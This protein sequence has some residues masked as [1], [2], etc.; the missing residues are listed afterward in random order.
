MEMEYCVPIGLPHS[1]FLSW[2]EMDQDKALAF[3]MWKSQFC[4]QCNT[5]NSGWVDERNRWLDEPEYDVITHKCFG[6]DAIDAMRSTIPEGTK[7]VMVLA[8]RRMPGSESELDERLVEAERRRQE[9]EMQDNR[10]LPSGG[11]YG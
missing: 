1:Q 3:L 10:T 4:P 8:T 2:P 9:Q 11:Y 6:C 7:G 5:R